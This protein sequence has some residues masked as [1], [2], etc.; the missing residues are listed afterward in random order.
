MCEIDVTAQAV[1]E[2]D[3]YVR[4][5][6][7]YTSNDIEYQILSTKLYILSRNV[8]GFAINLDLY[9][10]VTETIYDIE[11][12]YAYDTNDKQYV[13]LLLSVLI[14]LISN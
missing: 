9:K 3:Y 8:T 4:F 12:Y 11:G 7:Q 6:W 2:D 1:M 5:A 13:F 10:K 14:Y